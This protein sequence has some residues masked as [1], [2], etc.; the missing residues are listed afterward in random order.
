M[1]TKKIYLT[2]SKVSPTKYTIAI[3]LLTQ[4][5]TL[6]AKQKA[7]GDLTLLHTDRPFYKCAWN[8]LSDVDYIQI[9]SLSPY[10]I[11]WLWIC[12]IWMWKQK[13]SKCFFYNDLISAILYFKTKE[14][15]GQHFVKGIDLCQGR[16]KKALTIT[17]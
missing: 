16:K 5:K 2:S 7:F 17:N 3:P 9:L 6:H 10:N 11:Y 4:G 15:F 12:F 8:R 14:L 13:S 1:N